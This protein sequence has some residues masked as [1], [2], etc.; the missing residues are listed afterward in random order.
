[1]AIMFVLNLELAFSCPPLG[2]NLFI[3]SFRF[4]RPVISLY[5][6]AMPFVGLLALALLV[7]TYVPRISNALVL[8]DIQ[9]WRD[10]A[11]RESY[12]ISRA[13]R[14]IDADSMRN[15]F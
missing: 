8:S 11:Q 4:N 15:Q 7:I 1:V 13:Q 9:K 12:W 6:L 10:Q 2:L 14:T 5:R 3:S